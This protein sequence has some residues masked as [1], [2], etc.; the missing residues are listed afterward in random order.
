MSSASVIVVI[1]LTAMELRVDCLFH[2]VKAMTWIHQLTEGTMT[3]ISFFSP[4]TA[5]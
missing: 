3:A 2:C 4:V 5:E 1:C